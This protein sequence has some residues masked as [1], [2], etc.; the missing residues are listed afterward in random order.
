MSPS[1]RT[2]PAQW[3]PALSPP[4][5]PIPVATPPKA[6][7]SR[8]PR[9]WYAALALLL[10]APAC[11]EMLSGSTPP[12]MFLNP[13]ILFFQIG[14]YGSGAL[15]IREVVR[16][17]GLG[18]RSVLVLGAAY[19]VLEEGLVVTSWFNPYWPDVLS[20][21]GYSRWLGTN[22]FWALSLT[23]YHAVVSITL[24]IVLAEALFPRLA[25]RPW[26]RRR[27]ITLFTIWLGLVSLLGLLGFG[28][29]GFR[30]LGYS[31]PP[32]TYFFALGLAISLVA[33]GLNLPR[34]RPSP[35]PRPPLHA[36]A[37]GP[38]AVMVGMYPPPT[39][40]YAWGTALP[41]PPLAPSRPPRR[42]PKLWTLR[43]AGF[44]YMLAFFAI[45]WGI[46]PAIRWPPLALL[47]LA[48]LGAFAAWRLFAWSRR[49]GWSARSRLALASGIVFFFVLLAPLVEFVAPPPGK[50]TAGMSLM[51]LVW[52]AF[53]IALSFRL[54][55]FER[56][57]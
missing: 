41:P 33:L 47:L 45:S 50:V 35:H 20:L 36:S 38:A 7:T 17:N 10:L 8:R 51:A 27:G 43:L 31:H 5:P 12:L 13:L 34:P 11:G 15:L 6:T 44:A 26:L 19:S 18:W 52:L 46:G 24:P 28:F 42:A 56:R 9:T 49:L 1:P 3:P 57:A 30:K 2:P 53:V 25:A 32:L 21:H 22:W 37:A 40:V 16:R 23:M 4:A 54:R 39:P 29:L 48:A 14:L 55:R